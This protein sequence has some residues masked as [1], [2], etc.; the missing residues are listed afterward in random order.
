MTDHELIEG[1]AFE[2]YQRF[3]A[4]GVGSC[5][6]L[7]LNGKQIPETPE[8]ACARRWRRLPEKV[9]ENFIAE[10]RAEDHPTED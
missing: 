7:N 10:A 2:I 3:I 6:V 8:Q 5:L 9:R 1:R 4:F